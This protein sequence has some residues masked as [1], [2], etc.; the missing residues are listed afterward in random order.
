MMNRTF[1]NNMQA[2]DFIEVITISTVPTIARRVNDNQ[3]ISINREFT[4][5]MR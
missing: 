3:I 4:A 2:L 5:G 1:A